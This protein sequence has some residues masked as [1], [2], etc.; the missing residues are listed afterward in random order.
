MAKLNIGQSYSGTIKTVEP[1]YA[2]VDVNGITGIVHISHCQDFQGK[3]L[4]EIFIPDNVYQF[5][6]LKI[7]EANKKYEFSYQ[8]VNPKKTKLDRQITPTASHFKNLKID[9]ERR[10]AEYGK[11][12]KK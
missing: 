2:I 6:C 9:V 11:N 1:S 3:N 7:D 10:L 5:V 12:Q 4:L 8:V